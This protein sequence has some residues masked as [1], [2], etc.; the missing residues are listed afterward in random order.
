MAFEII[1]GELYDIET[2]EHVG[3]AMP[4]NFR[5]QL[6]RQTTPLRLSPQVLQNMAGRL[7]AL[8]LQRPGP[9]LV[10]RQPGRI[11]ETPLPVTATSVAAGASAD[12]AMNAQI[13]F[14]P[15]RLIVPDSIASFFT[16]DAFSV[17][18]VPLFAGNGSIPAEAFRPDSVNPNV[19]KVTAQPGVPITIRVT[20]VDAVA[21][22]FRA[23]VFG[24]GAQ[25]Y[26]C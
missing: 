22:T 24:E 3:A 19:R 25:P 11:D 16:I 15:R 12:I 17:G 5:P 18:N 6:G 14:S 26:G 23:A 13:I 8:Q 21:H 20:N 10:Q 4:L 2:G 7:P 1:G 9:Q